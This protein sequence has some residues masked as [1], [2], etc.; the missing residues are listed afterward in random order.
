M[1]H[2]RLSL[3]T[4]LCY[5]THLL[6]S[7]YLDQTV[8]VNLE[9]TL[10]TD[11][12]F[13]DALDDM[14]TLLD[15]AFRSTNQYYN[16]DNLDT[17]NVTSLYGYFNQFNEFEYGAIMKLYFTDQNR[18]D[19]AE[20]NYQ[21]NVND[22][23]VAFVTKFEADLYSNAD[24][25]LNTSSATID[26]VE[27]QTFRIISFDT[28]DQS[29]QMMVRF[30]G[31]STTTTSPT[32]NSFDP[33]VQPTPNPSTTPTKNPISTTTTSQTSEPKNY[34]FDNEALYWVIAVIF[35]F[36]GCCIGCGCWG[37]LWIKTDIRKYFEGKRRTQEEP[38][39]R[40]KRKKER[41]TKPERETSEEIELARK[42]K[43]KEAARREAEREEL[44][45]KRDRYIEYGSDDDSA[46]EKEIFKPVV[47][48][49]RK[50]A[51]S[52]VQE[53]E[54]DVSTSEDVKVAMRKVSYSSPSEEDKL[55]SPRRPK[56]RHVNKKSG[57]VEP[58]RYNDK[59]ER[60]LTTKE[61]MMK[62]KKNRQKGGQSVDLS[63]K[64]G[65]MDRRRSEDDNQ[66]RSE[67]GDEQETPRSFEFDVN[68]L[69][70]ENHP[71]YR[72]S[73]P[74]RKLKVSD[75]KLKKKRQ[76][77]VRASTGGLN[78]I[79]SNRSNNS[80]RSHGSSPRGT[81][82]YRRPKTARNDRGTRSPGSRSSKG[83]KRSDKSRSPRPQS[84]RPGTRAAHG[85]RK[86]RRSPRHEEEYVDA[87]EHAERD[88]RR[89]DKQR[90]S[91]HRHQH[92]TY[93]DE[94]AYDEEY[95]DGNSGSAESY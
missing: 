40:K 53:E 93:D 69:E 92:D 55:K 87:Y 14:E 49:T 80:Q 65:G 46:K 6:S 57:A 73:H 83:K 25:L 21:N 11:A 71:H 38:P 12:K 62:Y 22:K 59:G 13:P 37:V 61:L 39:P 74:K 1:M 18:F 26:E 8:I 47:G 95:D 76:K 24:T 16:I 45:R 79:P 88:H 35:L 68:D 54:R 70:D 34:A 33:S 67:S 15:V 19:E 10:R 77:H 78:N 85:K 51:S 17:L 20:T 7:L 60:Q 2:H 48:K 52:S 5:L 81:G 94:Y 30:N 32:G 41:H 82:K 66:H 44:E 64:V 84:A 23:T 42:R 56:T 9:L 63:Y 27:I 89:R 86:K 29:G 3:L 72:P 75:K 90:G 28:T 4:S 43:K 91:R 36:V 50:V 31:E 58:I